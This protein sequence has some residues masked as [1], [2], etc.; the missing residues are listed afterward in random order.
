MKK[1]KTPHLSVK[2]DLRN[3]WFLNNWY[4]KHDMMCLEPSET[5]MVS[6]YFL[7]FCFGVVFFFLPDYLGRKKTMALVLIP[8]SIA[9]YMIVFGQD[10]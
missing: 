4:V 9:N 2:P 10:L 8:V 5:Q 7:G 1:L 6:S 3:K